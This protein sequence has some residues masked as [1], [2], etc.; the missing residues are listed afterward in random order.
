[1]LADKGKCK[2]WSHEE[3]QV[4]HKRDHLRLIW[5]DFTN[6]SSLSAEIAENQVDHKGDHLGLSFQ[7]SKDKT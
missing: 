7:H 3:S 2:V 6:A 1:M 5:F 4:A